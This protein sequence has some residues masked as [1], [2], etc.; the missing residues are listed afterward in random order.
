MRERGKWFGR[1]RA[2]E[3]LRLAGGHAPGH[4]HQFKE[5]PCS[6]L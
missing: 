5:T 1:D 2:G 3:S 6:V 4:F